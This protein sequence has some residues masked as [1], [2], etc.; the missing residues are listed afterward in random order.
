MTRDELI[1][2]L[3]AA[4]GPDR[5]IDFELC[6]LSAAGVKEAELTGH[7]RHYTS[8]IDAA[9]TLVPDGAFHGVGMTISLPPE[10]LATCSLYRDGYCAVFGYGNT[11]ALAACI[12][13][14]KAMED[15]HD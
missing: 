8:S 12:A 3:Q 4:S 7:I 5:S 10:T 6:E 13:A 9:L 11:P 2:A 14:L 1:A 15:K